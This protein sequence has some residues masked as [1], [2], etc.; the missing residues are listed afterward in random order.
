MK[1]HLKNEGKMLWSLL[2]ILVAFCL[3]G[4]L[5]EKQIWVV[6]ILGIVLAYCLY[7]LIVIKDGALLL[8]ADNLRV[9]RGREEV[10][11]DL[12]QISGWKIGFEYA[13]DGSLNSNNLNP[14]FFI[15][16]K[17]GDFTRIRFSES[18]EAH[19]ALLEWVQS[20]RVSCL[21]DPET[22]YT[23]YYPRGAT[24]IRLLLENRARNVSQ[25]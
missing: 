3:F 8:N 12:L 2:F 14:S 9:V 20:N 22:N 18:N 15:R 6:A 10:V 16:D 21:D 5:Y 11:L 23:E 24:E 7:R 13:F 19:I 4:F 25:L 17:K 1:F